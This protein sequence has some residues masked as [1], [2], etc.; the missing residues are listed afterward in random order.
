MTGHDMRLTRLISS[1][2]LSLSD[3]MG[4]RSQPMLAAI[5][6]LGLL[7]VAR[8]ALPGPFTDFKIYAFDAMQ[9]IAPRGDAETVAPGTGVVVVDIDDASLARI[10][11]WPWPR[12]VMADL[13]RHLQDAGASAIGLDVVFAEPDRASPAEVAAAWAKHDNLV[14]TTAD[15]HSPLPDYDRDLA[16]RSPAAAS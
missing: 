8:A 16:G 11:Q 12:S 14:V 13:I 6:A 7:V 4:R 9:R 15:G 1:R 5:A 2:F 3:G 10:G